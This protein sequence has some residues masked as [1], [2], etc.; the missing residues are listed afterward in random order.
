MGARDLSRLRLRQPVVQ[1]GLSWNL[2]GSDLRA[3][4]RL[5]QPLPRRRIA[6]R[7]PRVQVGPVDA[8]S[9]ASMTRS[10]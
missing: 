1:P 7:P 2:G 8:P 10:H 3:A 5:P 6:R 4:F 9:R